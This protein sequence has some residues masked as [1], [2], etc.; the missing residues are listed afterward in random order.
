MSLDHFGCKACKVPGLLGCGTLACT[1]DSRQVEVAVNVTVAQALQ[2]AANE[3]QLPPELQ[4]LKPTVMFF[5]GDVE[6]PIPGPIVLLI[7]FGMLE[8]KV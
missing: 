3:L 4:I 1:D 8:F 6:D 7:A 5:P 2:R